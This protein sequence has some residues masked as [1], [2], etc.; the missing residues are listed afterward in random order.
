MWHKLWRQARGLMRM[1]PVIRAGGLTR[2][3]VIKVSGCGRLVGIARRPAR[4]VPMLEVAEG[5]VP[6]SAGLEGD[7]KGAKYP[8]RQITVLSCEAWEAA[9]ADLGVTALP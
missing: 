2:A 6:A 9:L 4:L 8:R 1:V 7:F 3:P 5:V